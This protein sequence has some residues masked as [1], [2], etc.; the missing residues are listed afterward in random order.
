M[1]NRRKAREYAFILLFEY[2]FQPDVIND[3]I[4]DFFAENDAGKQ[5]EYIRDV[6]CGAISHIEEIDAVIAENSKAWSPDRIS[7]VCMAVMRLAVYEMKYVDSIPPNV[8]INEGVS[9]AV[10]YDGEESAPFVNGVLD[11]IKFR[12]K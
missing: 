6:V 3:I 4:E 8:S 10:E 1:M 5:E 2:R 7:N 12:I 11:K 9:L